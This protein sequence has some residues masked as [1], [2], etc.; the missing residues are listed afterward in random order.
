VVCKA[1]VEGVDLSITYTRERAK[2]VDTSCECLWFR[3]VTADA[4]STFHR[5]LGVAAQLTGQH[6]SGLSGGGSVGRIA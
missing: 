6:A 3:G 1:A 2:I 4:A 5:A